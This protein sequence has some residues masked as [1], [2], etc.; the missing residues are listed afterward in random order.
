MDVETNEIEDQRKTVRS[1]V[2]SS[3]AHSGSTEVRCQ[4]EGRFSYCVV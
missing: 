3:G 1:A 2:G 4:L